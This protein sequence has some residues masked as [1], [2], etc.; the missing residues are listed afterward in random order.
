MARTKKSVPKSQPRKKTK[1]QLEEDDFIDE[2]SPGP[3]SDED[4]SDDE[5]VSEARITRSATRQAAAVA[6][7]AGNS[8]PRFDFDSKQERLEYEA[9]H[10][11]QKEARRRF[12]EENE[13]QK[14]ER[15]KQEN[16]S[17]TRNQ[18]KRLRTMRERWKAVDNGISLSQQ[19]ATRDKTAGG[20]SAKI[21]HG[22]R[23][24]SRL[25]HLNMML[26]RKEVLTEAEHDEL[27]MLDARS[28]AM[29]MRR[30]Q[31]TEKRKKRKKELLQVQKEPNRK[32]NEATMTDD[33]VRAAASL[34]DQRVLVPVEV[35]E[36]H[37]RPAAEEQ[38]IR[39]QLQERRQPEDT[40][41]PHSSDSAIA[42]PSI[43]LAL[44]TILG[45]DLL[46]KSSH[47]SAP[48]LLSDTRDEDG[49]FLIVEPEDEFL[50]E[51]VM[52]TTAGFYCTVGCKDC[53]N[54]SV[55]ESSLKS[56]PEQEEGQRPED[57]HS[58][59]AMDIDQDLAKAKIISQELDEK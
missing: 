56:L 20:K 37:C 21:R 35:I 25:R 18:A 3:T 14:L 10:G 31:I 55:E 49:D 19:Q 34:R 52:W 8:K 53:S 39:P 7:H 38:F 30:T 48:S 42:R 47:F 24:K 32:D 59:S 46:L 15:K 43:A 23:E 58:S 13:I 27:E 26:H 54:C 1:R 5:E 45:R 4:T 36:M 12:H 41:W 9:V 50:E 28:T 57:V 11:S 6:T 16:G 29:P 17:L 40:T 22:R 2:E 44:E 33:T 51:S